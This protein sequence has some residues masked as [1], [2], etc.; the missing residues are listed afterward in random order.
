MNYL[1]IFVS[2]GGCRAIVVGGGLLAEAKCRALLKTAAE[3]VLFCQEPTPVMLQWRDECRLQLETR[4]CDVSDLQTARLVY[5]ASECDHDNTQIAQLSN[6]AGVWV[7][8]VDRPDACDFI[9]PAIVDRDPVVVAIGTEGT[10]PV[11]AQQIKLDV[12]SMLPIHLGV[13]ARAAQQFR[14]RVRQLLPGLPRRRFWTDFFQ[15]STQQ[16]DL[17]PA[18][19]EGTLSTLLAQ[20]QQW[21][22]PEGK[23]IFVGAGPGDPDLLTVKARRVIQEAD[24]I[25]YDRLVGDH[26]L[27][28]ARKEAKFINAGKKGFGVSMPQADISAHLLCEAS[29]GQIVV[30]L[31]GG[32]P[33]MFGRLDEE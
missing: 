12:E 11:L 1:P 5:A 17:S 13:V 21:A 9:T 27:D 23:V 8:V 4:A 25:V 7:N 15:R 3:V 6:E 33:G 14:H 26:I 20:H 2:T 18:A 31:K 29:Q 19:L 22:V 10:A 16:T 32:D 30:R 28:L 24:V